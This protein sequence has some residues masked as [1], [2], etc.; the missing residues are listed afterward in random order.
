MA[1]AIDHHQ[2]WKPV[3]SKCVHCGLFRIKRDRQR[4]VPMLCECPESL[5]RIA[6]F[7][8][9]NQ[10]ELDIP[11]GLQIGTNT[12]QFRQFSNTWRTPGGEKIEYQNFAGCR[13]S[14]APDS[15]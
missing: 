10:H 7:V 15:G 14:S 11:P 5:G 2:I 8:G 13:L 6:A 1:S 9:S 4:D 3:Q 12:L